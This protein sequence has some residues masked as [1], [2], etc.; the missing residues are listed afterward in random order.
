[1]KTFTAAVRTQDGKQ[2]FH[3]GGVRTHEEAERAVRAQVRGAQVVLVAER[4]APPA[5]DG[6]EREAA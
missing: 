5:G 6:N 3:V 4:C 2:L 1:M